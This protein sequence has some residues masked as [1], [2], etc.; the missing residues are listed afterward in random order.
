MYIGGGS[1]GPVWLWVLIK[2][3]DGVE[4]PCLHN[5]RYTTHKLV[6]WKTSGFL[7]KGAIQLHHSISKIDHSLAE[8]TRNG[9]AF[10]FESCSHRHHTL[11][12][13]A[14]YSSRDTVCHTH[15]WKHING[16]GSWCQGQLKV[17]GRIPSYSKGSGFWQPSFAEGSA[18]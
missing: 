6:T 5:L 10:C 3:F 13:S 12:L 16:S 14:V 2:F 7:S 8:V 1:K 18:Y 11:W 4:R 9:T 17:S 15:C